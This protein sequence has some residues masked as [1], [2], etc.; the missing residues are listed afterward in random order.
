MEDEQIQ[1]IL[2]DLKR[3]LKGLQEKVETYDWEYRLNRF[4]EKV[5]GRKKEALVILEAIKLSDNTKFSDSLKRREC[6]VN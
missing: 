1:E 6:Q 5:S 3:D 4:D 2:S